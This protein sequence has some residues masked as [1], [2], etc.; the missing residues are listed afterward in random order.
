MNGVDGRCAA[1]HE[2][3]GAMDVRGSSLWMNLNAQP[4]SCDVRLSDAFVAPVAPLVLSPAL[5]HAGARTIF[6]TD[7]GIVE[8]ETAEAH[9]QEHGHGCNES[10]L[11]RESAA[12]LRYPQ[13]ESRLLPAHPQQA[14]SHREQLRKRSPVELEPELG[15]HG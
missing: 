14:C 6:V 7:V 12:R 1:I 5:V 15:R 13:T 4:R 10:G 2:A 3:V 9:N 8:H 11:P